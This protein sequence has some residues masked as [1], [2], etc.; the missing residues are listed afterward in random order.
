MNI[1]HDRMETVMLQS[2]MIIQTGITCELNQVC[3]CIKQTFC[4]EKDMF[5]LYIN[6]T[7]INI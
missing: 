5:F 1:V 3:K 4:E 2:F 7:E 6:G